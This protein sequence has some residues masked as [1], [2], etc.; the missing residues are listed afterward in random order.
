MLAD[1]CHYNGLSLCLAIDL[2]YHKRSGELFRVVG[3]R[4][5]VFVIYNL[6]NPLRMTLLCQLLIDGMQNHLQIPGHTAGDQHIFIHLCFI[7]I[8]LKNL[9]IFRKFL[10]ISCHTVTKARAGH[11]QQV[12]FTDTVVGR[13]RSMHP[14]HAGIQ[15]IC[16]RERTLSHK[17]ICHWGIHLFHKSAKFLTGA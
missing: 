10:C 8:K 7:N 16:S 12:A 4:I 13:L 15:W 6:P 3:Q 11:N 14:K 9:C 17:G 5:T 1:L 2:F